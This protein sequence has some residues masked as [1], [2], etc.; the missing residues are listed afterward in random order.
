[1][2]GPKA[3]SRS[4]HDLIIWQMSVQLAKEIYILTS[5]F[6]GKEVYG[7]S[8][9]L[10]RAAVSVPSNIAE[11]QARHQPGDF[12]RFLG[13]ALGSLAELETQLILAKEF[14]YIEASDLTPLENTI[15]DIRKKTYALIKTLPSNKP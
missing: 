5:K 10:R 7:L 14:G 4:F 12:R 9:Q 13:I 11:G 2:D 1:V 15:T 8:D 3:K 6:P